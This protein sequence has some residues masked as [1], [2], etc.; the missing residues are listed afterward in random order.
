MKSKE[1]PITVAYS[2]LQNGN[3]LFS[4][5]VQLSA[6]EG[7]RFKSQKDGLTATTIKGTYQL[8]LEISY[9][10]QINSMIKNFSVQ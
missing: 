10:D 8:M 9:K 5:K 1:L 6:P 2:F 7:I 3:N 4:E